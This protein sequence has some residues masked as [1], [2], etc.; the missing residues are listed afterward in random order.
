[1]RFLVDRYFRNRQSGAE[2]GR[3]RWGLHGVE[4][5]D[6]AEGINELLAE[7]GIAPLQARYLDRVEGEGSADHLG[8][9][10]RLLKS[11]L[12]AG[13]PP[14]LNLRSFQVKRREENARDPRWESA[15][16]HYV[17][18]TKLR[19][20]TSE[21]GF[22]VEVIDPFGGRR[23]VLYLHLEANGQPFRALKGNDK[24]GEWLAGRP[25]LQVVAP[26]VPTLRPAK[27]DWSERYLVVANHLIGR[28]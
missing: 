11:S 14:V 21:I 16:S 28:F 18:V 27:P 15:F 9:V 26:G 17:L 3:F 1:M 6:F 22:E 12:D 19:G 8:R 25:F 24:S 13:V 2:P 20:E 7:H 4:T 5:P 23:T 10:R